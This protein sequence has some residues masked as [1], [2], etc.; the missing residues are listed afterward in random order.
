MRLKNGPPCGPNAVVLSISPTHG[1]QVGKTVSIMERSSID[2][3]TSVLVKVF[4]D[5]GR[6]S[7]TTGRTSFEA[8]RLDLYEPGDIFSR[9][10]VWK[11][12]EVVFLDD[13]PSV[14]GRV[15]AIDQQQVVVDCGFSQTHADLV[16]GESTAKSSLKVFKLSELE[17]CIEGPDFQPKSKPTSSAAAF[18][19][20]SSSSIL[21]EDST[22]LRHSVS[23]HVAGTVQHRP[24][25]LLD[26]SKPHQLKS[27]DASLSESPQVS[28]RLCG[29]SP[30][31]VQATDAGP[32]LLVEH[33]ANG[34]A[35]LVCSAHLNTTALNATSFVALGYRDTKAKRC[36]ISEESVSAIEG[37]LKTNWPLVQAV[38]AMPTSPADIMTEATTKSSKT[39]AKDADQKRKASTRKGKSLALSKTAQNSVKGSAKSSLFPSPSSTAVGLGTS[40]TCAHSIPPPFLRSEFIAIK[41]GQPDLFFIRDTSGCI[42]PLVDGLSLQWTADGS[43]SHGTKRLSL[44]LQSYR[45]VQSR[46]YTTQADGEVAV[47]VLGML[48]FPLSLTLTLTHSL[49]NSLTHSLTH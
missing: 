31:A 46:Q 8:A 43:G 17:A 26:P 36:T 47:F 33:V 14:L 32:N 18:P 1:P 48:H 49:T 3:K 5:L 28:S 45:S 19:P 13:S 23:R 16:Q 39:R 25:C 40:D 2:P 27:F 24:V 35:H 41:A 44:P 4:R 9:L 42:W 38:T 12:S 21:S 6:S 11:L 29:F 30:L 10:E 34:N 7:T 37:G 15:V 22:V 20:S